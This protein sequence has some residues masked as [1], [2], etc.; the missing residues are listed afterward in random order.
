MGCFSRN[1]ATP[2]APSV[3]TVREHGGLMLTVNQSHFAL[4]FHLHDTSLN[5][6]TM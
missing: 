1:T 4:T 6:A 3:T 5:I 2:L